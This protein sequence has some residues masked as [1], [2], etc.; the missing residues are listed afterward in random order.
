M[1]FAEIIQKLTQSAQALKLIDF[2]SD[3]MMGGNG[4]AGIADTDANGAISERVAGRLDGS[5]G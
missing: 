1:T 3:E 4:A 2:R 5:S